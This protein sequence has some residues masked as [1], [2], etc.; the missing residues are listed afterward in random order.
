M[1]ITL[2]TFE[3]VSVAVVLCFAFHVESS[4]LEQKVVFLQVSE[5]DCSA[6]LT[7]RNNSKEDCIMAS[8][9]PFLCVVAL[10]AGLVSFDVR[11][12]AIEHDELRCE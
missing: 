1:M 3:Q 4:S 6:S 10:L 12:A 7:S 9:P 2:G 11:V 8:T 5:S